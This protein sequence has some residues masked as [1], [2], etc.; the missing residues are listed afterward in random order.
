[1]QSEI[2]NKPKKFKKMAENR[3]NEKRVINKWIF[4]TFNYPYNFIERCWSDE[5]MLASH[6]RNKFTQYQGD[7][8]R[9]YCELDKKNSDKLLNWV[10]D[11]Y[12]DERKLY[13]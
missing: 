3:T 6:I 4:F 10:L 12:T 9:L 8:S 11:N 7:M 13:G 1:L 2:N 5:P